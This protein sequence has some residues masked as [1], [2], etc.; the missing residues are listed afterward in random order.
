MVQRKHRFILR[1]WLLV[2]WLLVTVLP[3]SAQQQSPTASPLPL[4]A[5]PDPRGRFTSSSTMA[6]SRDNQTLVT[7][8]Q[9]NSTVSIVLP[10]Q[11]VLVMEIPVGQDPRSVALTDD[12]SMAVVTNRVDGTLSLVDINAQQAVAAIPL[13][14]SFPYGVV[15]GDN[16]IAYVA[17]QASS[18]IAI[19]D[20]PARQV[21]GYIST[22]PLPTGLALWGNFLYVTHF[23]SGQVSLIYLPERQIVQTV[24]TGVDTGLSPTIELDVTRG[25]AYLPQT[26]SNAQ[27]TNLTFDT[28]VFPVVN[29]LNL[30]NL[31]LLRPNRINLD[32]A[33]RPVN[34]PFA[35]ALDR[36]QNRLYIANAGSNSVTVYDLDTGTARASIPV[37]SNPRGILLNRDN[38]LL[39]V[40]NVLEGT[41][42]VIQTSNFEVIDQLPISN[43]TIP[44]DALLGAQYFYSA[45]NPRLSASSWVSCGSCHFDGLSDGRVW[46][47]FPDGPRNTPVLFG[48]RETP[49]YNWSATWDEL[50]D[51][52]LKIRGLQAGSG[53]LEGDLHP[54][55][56]DPHAGLSLDLDILANYLTSLTAP[57]APTIPDTALIERGQAVFE[58]Q[59]CARCHTLPTGTDLQQYDVGTGNGPHERAG[60]TFDVPA[61]RGLALSAPYFHDGRAP[62]LRDVFILPGDHQL[63][64]D[65]AL[66]D[67]DAL[68]AYLFSLPQS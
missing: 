10:R 51:V 9:L 55:L 50:Q 68:A 38:S 56:G 27:N 63:A 2:G 13:G 46:Q 19:V 47:G 49:P 4:Y 65:V 16:N 28:I 1:W 62:T 12:N 60:E 8:N 52:E 32:T 61:L 36:F 30:S 7:A 66:H 53:L 31:T 33:D 67:L 39:F 18:Q 11:R 64:F 23:W 6:L 14:G 25:L 17:L 40:H 20:L 22:P 3:A 45:D 58:E 57:P 54:P 37:D 5:L 43:L 34:L 48:V 59:N 21:I 41:L 24:A 44:V 26:R 35:L 15:I 29:V 42:T